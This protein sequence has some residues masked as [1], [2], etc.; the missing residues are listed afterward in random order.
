[1]IVLTLSCAFS[2][3]AGYQNIAA[4]NRT[5]VLGTGLATEE[6]ADIDALGQ[7]LRAQTT[8]DEIIIGNLDPVYHL[9]TGRKAIRA[10][11]A[12]PFALFY[13]AASAINPL[14]ESQD[15]LARIKAA[16]ATVVIE[17]PDALFAESPWLNRQIGDLERRG[18]LHEVD[19]IGRFRILR[20]GPR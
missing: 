19:R 10:F 18:D 12:D 1:M 17:A 15:F 4:A 8:A 5:G 2:I 3:R 7:R 11:E 9:L 14:G 13:T 16:G 20:P 6:W